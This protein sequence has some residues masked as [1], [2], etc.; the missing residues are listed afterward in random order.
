[1]QFT[2]AR[3]LIYAITL[4]VVM[5]SAVERPGDLLTF[6]LPPG[7]GV[8]GTIVMDTEKSAQYLQD[9]VGVGVDMDMDKLANILPVLQ[10]N[11]EFLFPEGSGL[12]GSS[13]SYFPNDVE[14][15]TQAAA[16]PKCKRCASCILLLFNFPAYVACVIACFAKCR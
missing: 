16:A 7:Y 6:D 12:E 14:L 11:N 4:T 5:A 2:V 1:M 8:N 3:S 15:S 9:E 13:I 10:E